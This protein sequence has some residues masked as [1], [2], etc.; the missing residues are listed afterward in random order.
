MTRV[1][2]GS[3]IGLVAA[4]F[5]AGPGL[6]QER[7]RA[8]KSDATAAC[9]DMM[10]VAGVTEEGKQ[11]MRELMQSDRAPQSMAK[12]MEMARRMGNGDVMVGMTRMMEMMGG[13]GMMAPGTGQPAK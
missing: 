5:V 6:A 7:A 4:A 9:M 8:S 10:Q 11:A 12:M 2:F 13:Q 1:L 3:V